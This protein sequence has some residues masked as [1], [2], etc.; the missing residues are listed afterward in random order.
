[1]IDIPICIPLPVF[2]IDSIPVHAPVRTVYTGTRTV[3]VMYLYSTC[4][5]TV[6]GTVQFK[7]QYRYRSATCRIIIGDPAILTDILEWK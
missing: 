7:V 2:P 1:M 6:Q 5:H 4:T 3:P